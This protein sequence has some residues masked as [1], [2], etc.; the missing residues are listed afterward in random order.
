MT[1]CPKEMSTDEKRKRLSTLSSNRMYMMGLEYEELQKIERDAREVLT[2]SPEHVE[3]LVL[4][5]WILYWD[6]KYEEA[7]KVLLKAVGLDPKSF[8]AWLVLGINYGALDKWKDAVKALK[9]AVEIDPDSRKAQIELLD[10]HMAL[11][12]EDESHEVV[13][14]IL[15]SENGEDHHVK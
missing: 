10:A 8:D 15:Y 5:G 12:N 4:L 9:R 14:S 11:G 6:E 2:E 1:D 13:W 3:C 7:E